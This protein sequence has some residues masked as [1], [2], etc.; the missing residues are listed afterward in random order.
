MACGFNALSWAVIEFMNNL[1]M[2]EFRNK[3]VREATINYPFN[4]ELLNVVKQLLNGQETL[5]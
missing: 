5:P 2:L 3:L 1:A 4:M